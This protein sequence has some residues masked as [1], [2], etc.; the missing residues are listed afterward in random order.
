MYYFEYERPESRAQAVQCMQG[1]ARYL[2]GGQSLIQAMKL[3]LSASERLVDLG[4]I[5][6]LKGIRVD[7]GRVVIGAMTTH[8]IVAQSFDVRAAIPALTVLAGGIGDPM[9]RNMGTIGGS[10]A[11]ADPA[12][13]YPAA[14]LGL[15]GIVHTDRREIK[16]DD[17]FTGLY[18]TALEPGELITELSFPIPER[19]AYV[20]FKQPASR[21]ALVGVF[22][23]KL[24]GAVRLAVTGAKSTVFR[25]IDMEDALSHHFHPDAVTSID[26]D[27]VGI[28]IDMH[29][30]CQ[31]RADLI[32][33]IAARAVAQALA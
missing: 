32:R 1:D 33:V 7:E 24:G 16:S 30:T 5:S 19:A 11:N 6:D 25:Q 13:C 27:V 21:F 18:E 8:A 31:Y 15:G 23:S 9:V 17:F 26:V 4:G 22:V 3:R 14:L 12:A 28:N 10:L 2:A 20:K 29:G